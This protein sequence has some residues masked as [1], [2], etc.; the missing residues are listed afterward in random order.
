MGRILLAVVASVL[1]APTAVGAQPWIGAA[2]TGGMDEQALGIYKADT[3]LLS[4]NTTSTASIVTR[5]TVT[6]TSGTGTPPWTNLELQYFDNSPNS[7]VSA[8]LY[9]YTASGGLTTVTSCISTDAPYLTALSCSLGGHAVN[10]NTGR[11]YTLVVTISRTS[12]SATPYFGG[13]RLY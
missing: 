2:G 5:Y 3:G 12:S 11:I 13:V 8:Y 4:Y 10:F 7:T 9:W 1:I 6:D